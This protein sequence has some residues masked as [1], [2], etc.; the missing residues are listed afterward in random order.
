MEYKHYTFNYFIDFCAIDFF[1]VSNCELSMKKNSHY[2]NKNILI[3]VVLTII[4]FYY[5]ASNKQNRARQR[6]IS[7]KK[8]KKKYEFGFNLF[9]TF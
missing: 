6:P 9:K 7:Q 2:F 5:K 8:K 3:L 4:P 1:V